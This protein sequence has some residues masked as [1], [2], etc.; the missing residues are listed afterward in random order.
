M[1]FHIQIKCKL[2]AFGITF[3]TVEKQFFLTLPGLSF[4][5][6]PVQTPPPISKTL[7]NERGV[8]L[9]VWL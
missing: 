1:Q 9:V 5:N 3:G 2:R 6:E 8:S 7:V 4:N